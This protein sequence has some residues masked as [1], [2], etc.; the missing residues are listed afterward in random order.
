MK[1]LLTLAALLALAYGLSR[2][3]QRKREQTV[4]DAWLNDQE[5]A[6]LRKS[7]QIEG[8][9]WKWPINKVKDDHGAFNAHRLRKRA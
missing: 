3:L 4:S 7:A 8:V 6:F 2:V 9:A 1:L 5:R